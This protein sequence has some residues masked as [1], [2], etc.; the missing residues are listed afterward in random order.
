MTGETHN[1]AHSRT[2]W[3]G[4]IAAATVIH[5]L[6]FFSRPYAGPVQYWLTIV[7]HTAACVGPFWMFADWFI[8]R[9]RR[10]KWKT[11]MWLFFVP[12]GFLWYILE[13]RKRTASVLQKAHN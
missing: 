8:K 7:V 3:V 6:L 2:F 10:L 12:W 13:K 1:R 11:W 9:R 5:F 4:V